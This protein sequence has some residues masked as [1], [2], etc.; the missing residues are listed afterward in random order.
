MTQRLYNYGASTFISPLK[1]NP[2]IVLIAIAIGSLMT[3]CSTSN[4]RNETQNDFIQIFA[5]ASE[6]GTKKD[7]FTYDISVPVQQYVVSCCRSK[8]RA[9]ALLHNEGF[10][11]GSELHGSEKLAATKSNYD[12]E[13]IGEKSAGRFLYF[14]KY[15]RVVLLIKSGQVGAVKA[16]SFSDSL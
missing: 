9:L 2:R 12:E 10:R 7:A 6:V 11:T 4:A 14:S 16:F 1:R 8:E 15:Y 3:A 5:H 13:I